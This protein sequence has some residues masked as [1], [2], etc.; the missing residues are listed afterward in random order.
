MKLSYASMC[1][2][3]DEILCKGDNTY[4]CFYKNRLLIFC[5]KECKNKFFKTDNFNR[6][7]IKSIE[8]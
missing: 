8:F 4:Q 2:Y 1:G 7:F 5:D 6:N 3:C